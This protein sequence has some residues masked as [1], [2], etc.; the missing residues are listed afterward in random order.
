ME[1]K[2]VHVLAVDDDLNIRAILRR[3][4][5]K[6]EFKGKFT[7]VD[8]GDDAWKMLLENIGK[9]SVVLLDRM[10]PGMSGMDLLVRMKADSRFKD[11]PV[12][13][14]TAMG[15]IDDVAEGIEA[16]VFYYMTKPYPPTNEFLAIVRAAVDEHHRLAA[17]QYGL[18]EVDSSPVVIGTIEFRTRI[19]AHRLAILLAKICPDP[20]KVAPGLEELLVNGVEHGN[21]GFHCEQKRHMLI[22]NTWES[23]LKR[24]LALRENLNKKVRVDVTNTDEEIQFRIEDE[25]LG[26]DWKDYLLISMER[27]GYPNGRGIALAATI[28]FDR[29]EYFGTGNVVV[30]TVKRTA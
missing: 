26:F 10:M 4:L 5:R 17:I 12:I 8:S 28:Y 3:I 20:E 1:K 22:A 29:V 24:C 6:S 7:I 30:A 27:I 21:L 23:E 2:E 15:Q 16:G 13:F 18:S 9:Y 11:I 14:Q 19:E 25:G